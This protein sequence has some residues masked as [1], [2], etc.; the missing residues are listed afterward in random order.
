M[1]HIDVDSVGRAHAGRRQRHRRRTP[2]D[3]RRRGRTGDIAQQEDLIGEGEGVVGVMEDGNHGQLCLIGQFAHRTQHPFLVGEIEIGGGLVE[4]ENGCFLC[5]GSGEENHLSFSSAQ[6]REGAFGKV[7]DAEP[8]E[9][10]VRNVEVVRR[11][12]AKRLT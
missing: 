12:P 3:R 10:P 5:Q 4:Y 9:R 11:W 1:H 2:F 8:A 6:L 7:G